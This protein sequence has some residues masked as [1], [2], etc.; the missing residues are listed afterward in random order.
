MGWISPLAACGSAL[1]FFLGASICCAQ[2]MDCA[3]LP[4]QHGKV[5]YQCNEK[6]P[7]QLFVIGICHPSTVTRDIKEYTLRVQAEVFKIGEWLVQNQ[8]VEL[9]LPEGYF[10]KGKAKDRINSEDGKKEGWELQDLKSLEALLS[11]RGANAELL[12][13]NRYSLRMQQVEDERLY[14]AG[15]RVLSRMRDGTKDA[16]EYRTLS[17][18]LKY[19]GEMRTASILQRSPEIIRRE[20]KEGHIKSQKAALTIGIYHLAHIIRY[21]QEREIKV[22]SPLL[23]SEV[24][25]DYLAPLNLLKENYGIS[26]ILPKTLAEDQKI[27]RTNGLEREVLPNGAVNGT[28]TREGISP[29]SPLDPARV[30]P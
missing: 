3:G 29:L 24:R 23:A 4:P 21:L 10:F 9:L 27:L 11:E 14:Q 26:L 8:G 5:L 6:A 19:L 15:Y 1:A 17:S 18:K 7:H 20:F 12:L 22:F 16:V 28:R 13:K 25:P 30:G 2:A